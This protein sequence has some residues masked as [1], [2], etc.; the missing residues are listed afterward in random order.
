MAGK[1]QGDLQARLSAITAELAQIREQLGIRANEP[2]MTALH[3]FK[4]EVDELRRF[5]WRC[6]TPGSRAAHVS[7]ATPMEGSF[8]DSVYRI[9]DKAENI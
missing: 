2:D 8:M 6:V 1:P 7:A 9:V 3:A 5:L 4:Q